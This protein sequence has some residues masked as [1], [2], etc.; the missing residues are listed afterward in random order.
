MDQR[1][2]TPLGS[3]QSVTDTVAA[4]AAPSI[5]EK[6]DSVFEAIWNALETRHDADDYQSSNSTP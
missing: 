2:L 5:N 1:S 6:T 4:V 3:S